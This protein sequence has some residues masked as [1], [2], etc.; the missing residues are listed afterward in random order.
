M[1]PASEAAHTF[2]V[3]SGRQ[4]RDGSGQWVWEDVPAELFDA[5]GMPRVLMMEEVAGSKILWVGGF[6]GLLRWDLA[7][8]PRGVAEGPFSVLLR[9]A[10][11][12]GGETIYA[13]SEALPERVT[14]DHTSQAL[15]FEFATPVFVEGV[16]PVMETRLEG[17]ES[18]WMPADTATAREFTNLSE[19]R[20]RF[21]VR[22]SNTL[23]QVAEAR[24]FGFWVRPPWYRTWWSY[25]GYVLLGFAGMAGTVRW[26][27]AAIRRENERLE[28]I[29]AERTEDL[30]EACDE[31]DRANRAKSMFLA[32]M[33]HELRTPLNGIL[34]YTQILQRDSSINREN[35]QRLRVLQSSGEHLLRLINEVLDLSKIESGRIELHRAPAELRSIVNAVCSAFR[36]RIQEKA[37]EF[38]VEVDASL[39]ERV[40]IDEQKFSQVL[41]NL[42]G[43]AVKF[44]EHGR[45]ELR[46]SALEDGVR[47]EVIDTGVGIPPEEQAL[48][49]QPFQQAASR[50]L[51]ADGTGL[52]LTICSRIVAL[53]GGQLQVGSLAG[54]GSRFWFDVPLEVAG[55]AAGRGDL[56]VLVTGYSGP[57]RRVLVVDDVAINRSIVR[58]MLDP[59]GFTVAEA[60]GG[61]ECLLAVE[62]AAPDLILLD[63]RMA[64]M[65][66]AEVVRR[67]RASEAGRTIKVVSFSAST[68]GF[69][70][71]DAHAI[72]CDD[73]L[74]KPFREEELLE[75]L[76]RQLDLTWERKIP[77]DASDGHAL[78][79]AAEARQLLAY[80]RRGDA[81]GLRTALKKLAKARPEVR[82]FVEELDR[83]AAGYRMREVRTRLEK[84][85]SSRDT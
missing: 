29:I 67:L 51:Q 63:L 77:T 34:G 57:R 59:L 42:L 9:R 82:G 69:T 66:G 18:E 21:H 19:G 14:I 25:G 49:F 81:T 1:Y 78:P 36:P 24:T 22:A 12:S 72:G 37:L 44:T 74:P 2:D 54:R 48:I 40:I 32:N 62:K 7:A 31:A 30:R 55:E 4:F 83:I 71:E 53:M 70:R 38:I 41:F 43:N 73:Y 60:P 50:P 45:V 61:D 20:Y 13:G 58:E 84:L 52:G 6:E 75:V 5:I 39:P 47:I 35:R 46:V 68:M 76:Q 80:A 23:G 56:E 17:Y 3:I 11:I 33:S 64:P 65:S 28:R 27:L 26:R 79:D 8:G 15:R 16:R 10:G 85:S